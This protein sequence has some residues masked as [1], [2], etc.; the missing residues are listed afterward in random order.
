[1]K[2]DALLVQ[3]LPQ[4]LVRDVRDHPLGDHIV[5]QLGQAPSRKRLPEIGRD[6]ERDLLDLLALRQREGLRPPAAVA[7]IE[8]VEAVAVE[9]M[10]QLAHRV[11]V[12]EDDLADPGR[13]HPLRRQQDDL[14]APPGHDRAAAA[15]HD[16]QQPVALLVADLAQLHPC[17]H[18]RPPRLDNKSE[19]ALRRGRRGPSTETGERCRSLH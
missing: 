5:G 10:D 14:R 16:P 15:T 1:L 6:A 13:T 4:P 17:R 7:R 8:R 19:S 12:G 2:A 3:Q 9:V 18:H 11:W